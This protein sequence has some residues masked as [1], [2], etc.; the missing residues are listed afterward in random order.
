MTGSFSAALKN[1]SAPYA[2]SARDYI[3]S[4]ALGKVILVK[5]YCLLGGGR[6]QAQPDSAAPAGL[7]WDRWLGPARKVPYNALRHRR[8]YDYWEYSGGSALAGDASHCLDLARLAVGD[9]GHPQSVFCAGGNLAFDHDREV[10]DVQAITYDFGDFVMTCESGLFTPYMKKSP[11]D[12]RF[13]EKFP[14][15]PQNATRIEIYGTKQMM[16]L[17]RHGGGWQVFAG[18]RELAAQEYGKFPDKFHQP[19]WIECIRSRQQPNGDVEQGHYSASLVHFGNLAYRTG[20][21]QLD[22]DS[23]SETF[24][25]SDSANAMLKPHYR[26]EY[27]I[28]HE[29]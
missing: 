4:G 14:N 26:K 28:T 24:T 12:V 18:D 13:G 3:S 22:F 29:V 21:R 23:D 2:F 17:G 20:N 8:N 27:R 7:D 5:V 19:N 16:Y 11:G 25:N 9:P 15:W 1:R 10:P 6:W